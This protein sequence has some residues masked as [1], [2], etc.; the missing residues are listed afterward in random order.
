MAQDNPPPAEENSD[1]W[2]GQSDYAA[3]SSPDAGVHPLLVRPSRWRRALRLTAAAA[4][5]I[6][7]IPALLTIAYV[8]PF[9]HP[10]SMLMASRHLS[11][12]PVDRRWTPLD[13][14]SPD[15]VRAVAMSEDG[16]FCSHFGVDVRELN[17]VIGDA[18]EG[19]TP[20]GASTITMQTVKNLFLPAGRSFLRKAAEMPLAVYFDLMTPKRRTLEIY[21]N[22]AE[23]GDGIFGAEA[24]ARRHFGIP[25]ALLTPR[26]AA[27]LAAA[28]PNPGKRNPAKPGDGMARIADVIE[29][30]AGK[31]GGY[32]ECVFGRRG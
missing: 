22:I 30:R 4:F 32:L 12:L 17:A 28:L 7:S 24:A 16:R 13:R 5:L 20:R 14:I 23:W 6:A 29:R 31:S 25:A 27:L 3:G 21:L 10:V 18:L 8:P 15:L 2:N 19:E 1:R 11:G 9:V 26:Q